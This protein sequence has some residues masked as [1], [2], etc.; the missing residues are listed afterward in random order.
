MAIAAA[1]SDTS[2][3]Q[4]HRERLLAIDAALAGEHVDIVAAKAQ[5]KVET[6]RVWVRKML[7]G[8]SIN[9]VPQ[10]QSRIRPGSLPVTE[11]EVQA[12]LA[13]E[14][15]PKIRRRLIALLAILRGQT[16]PAAAEIANVSP[17]TVTAWLK[18][19]RTRGFSTLLATYTP[20][21]R[22]RR[23]LPQASN[24]RLPEQL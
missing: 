12:A 16:I 19:L 5:V 23:S 11:H 14:A 1:L 17:E 24:S 10:P 13:N 22:R 7:R 21:V 8:G 6:L 9:V 20:S 3:R 4:R 15:H 18:R 2:L